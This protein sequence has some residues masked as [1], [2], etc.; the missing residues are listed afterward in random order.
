VIPSGT[1]AQQRSV[2]GAERT[3][4]GQNDSEYLRTGLPPKGIQQRR[5]RVP[6]TGEN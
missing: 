6:D 5:V 2:L 1:L 4:K 3:G